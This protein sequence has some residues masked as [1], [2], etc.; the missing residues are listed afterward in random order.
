MERVGEVVAGRRSSAGP[1]LRGQFILSGV[2]NPHRPFSKKPG[3]SVG[4]LSDRP[5]TEKPGRKP[6]PPSG[7]LSAFDEPW[8]ARTRRK[9]RVSQ[10]AVPVFVQVSP[11][12]AYRKVG[13][14]WPEERTARSRA[15]RLAHFPI[16][17]RRRNLD[18]NRYS[19]GGL[20]ESGPTETPGFLPSFLPAK[21]EASSAYDA[22]N[23]GIGKRTMWIPDSR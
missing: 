23:Q 17:R 7:I 18:E 11:S 3:V 19:V 14:S 16:G 22:T 8:F 9:L 10:R 5:P 13:P 2:G 21:M 1:G 12:A 4:P 20:S 15:F 6:V